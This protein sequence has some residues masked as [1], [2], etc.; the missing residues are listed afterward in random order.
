[1]ADNNRIKVSGYAKKI[2]FNDNIEYRNFS[3]DLVGFQ[4]TSEGGTTLFT[5]G[6]FS[7]TVN[8]DPKPNVLFTQGTKSKFYTLNDIS[9]SGNTE[10]EIQKNVRAKLNIDITNPLSYIWYGSTKELLRASLIEIEDNW[11]AAIYV[12]NKVGS[13]T[14]NNITNYVYD[15]SKDESTFIVNSNFFINPYNITYTLDSQYEPTESNKNKLRNFTLKY[16]SYVIEHNGIVKNIK[17]ITPTTYKTNSDLSL[18]V[19]GNPFPELTGIYIPQLSFLSNGVDASIPYFIKP[20]EIEI[21][22]FFSGLNELQTNLLNREI[23]P[24]YRSEIIGTKFT[25]AGVILNSKELY[26]FPILEDGYNLNFFDSFYISYLDKLNEFTE[27]LDKTK[28]DLILRKYTTEVI[29]SFDTIPRG[30]GDDLTLN[31]EKVTNLLRIYGVEFDFIKKFINGIKFANV[32]TYNKKNN[33]PDALVKDLSYMLG[34]DP[35]NFISDSSLN[36]LYL[37]SNGGG[38]FS[39]TSTNLTQDQIDFELYRRLILNIAW[40]WKS[41]GSRKAIE[42]LFR[43]IGAPES[44]VNFNEYIVIVDKPLD[45]EEIKKLLYI[46]TG[47]V[48]LTNIPYD[49]NGFPLPPIDGNLVVSNFIDPE[50]GEIVENGTTDMYFQKAGGWYRDTYGDS[51]PTVLNGNNPHIGPYDGG[52]EYLQYFS[53]CYIPNFDNEPTVVLTANTIQE[54][55]FINYNYGIFNGIPKGTTEFY[56]S[57]LTFN[58]NTNKYQP[59]GSCVDINYSIIETPLQN[60]GKTTLQQAYGEAESQYNEFLEKIKKDKYL[61]YSPEWQVI[62]NNYE[63]SLKN[64]LTEIETENCDTNNTLEICLNDIEEETVKFNC[65]KTNSVV[66][67]PFFYFTNNDGVKVSVD[68]FDVC[69]SKLGGKH[70]SYINE[71]GRDAEFCYTGDKDTGPC[72]GIPQDP[73]DNGIIPFLMVNNTL[74]NNVIQVNSSIDNDYSCYQFIYD[75]ENS[76]FNLN[77][78]LENFQSIYGITPQQYINTYL[79]TGENTTPL[80]YDSGPSFESLFSKVSCEQTSVVSSPECCAYHGYDYTILT[81]E[82]KNSY[83]ACLQNNNNVSSLVFQ[84]NLTNS[85]FIETYTIPIIDTS[86]N[87]SYYELQ[88]PV[89]NVSLY[90]TTN[91]FKDCFEESVIVKGFSNSDDTAVVVPGPNSDFLNSELN[92]PEN[93]E[94]SSIDVYGR[95]SFKPLSEYNSNLIVDWNSTGILALLYQQIAE[96]YPQYSF[97]TFVLNDNGQVVPYV[98]SNQSTPNNYFIALVDPELVICQNFNNIS[99]MFGSE[100]WQGFKLPEFPVDETTGE[101]IEDCSCSIDFSFDYMLKYEASNLIECA[102]NVSCF[103]AIFYENSVNNINCRN[104]ISFTNNSEDSQELI[105]RFNPSPL[106]SNDNTWSGIDVNEPNV[107]CCSA[108]GGNVVSVSQ[109]ATSNQIW[110]NQINDIYTNL[111]SDNPSTEILDNLSNLNIVYTDMLFYIQEYKRIKSEVESNIGSCFS[112]TLN[113][114]NCNINYGNY[115]NTQS[116]CNLE[117]PVEC[118]LWT[119]ILTDLESLKNGISNLISEYNVQCISPNPGP[120]DST[121]KKSEEFF[122]GVEVVKKQNALTTQEETQLKVLTES[123]EK[124]ILEINSLQSEIDLKNSDNAVIEKSLTNVNNPLDCNVYENKLTELRN[125]DYKSYCNTIV[126]GNPSSNDGTKQNEYNSCTKSKTLE[127]QN[128]EVTYSQLLVSCREKNILESQLTTAKFEN[129]ITLINELEKEIFELNQTINRLTNDINNSISFDESKQKSLLEQNDIQ[130]TINRTS[131]L[132]NVTPESITD[133]SGNILLTSTQKIN[134]N[135]IYSKNIT[136]INSLNTKIDESRALLTENLEKQNTI[137]RN[138]KNE[139]NNLGNT[140]LGW[141]VGLL[142]IYYTLKGYLDPETTGVIM[143]AVGTTGI[144]G[145]GGGEPIVKGCVISGGT[146]YGPVLDSS[147]PTG[148]YFYTLIGPSTQAQDPNATQICDNFNPLNSGQWFF[149]GQQNGSPIYQNDCCS[150]TRSSSNPNT[151][152]SSGGNENSGIPNQEAPVDI[153]LPPS[154]GVGSN[155]NPLPEAEP[156]KDEPGTSTS[157][158]SGS[159]NTNEQGCVWDEIIAQPDGS[160]I[161]LFNGQTVPSECCDR[162]ILLTNFDVDFVNGE[163]VMTN[164]SVEGTVNQTLVNCCSN[165]NIEKL[166]ELLGETDIIYQEV[167]TITQNCYDSWGNSLQETYQEYEEINNSYYANYLDD[168]KVNFKLFVNNST[169]D[170]N[171]EIDSNLTYLPYTESVNPI[172]T[173]N[174]TTGYT[175]IILEGTE[176]EIATIED[177]IFNQLSTQNITYNADMFEPNWQTFNFTIPECVC[178]DL[179]RLYPNKEF[180]FSIEIENYECSLCLLVDNIQV[181]VSDCKTQRLLSINDCM[182]PQL[183]CV[184]DNKKSWVYYDDGVVTENVYPNGECNTGS[185]NNYEVVRL[186][187]EQERLWLDLEYR[188]TD[189]NVNHSDLILN[190]KNSSFSIDPAKAIECDVFNYWKNIDCDNCPTKCDEDSK[191]YEDSDDFLFQDCDTYIFEGQSTEHSVVFSGEV[192][193]TGYTLSFDDVVTTGLI[194]SCSTYTDS[195]EQTVL[196]LKNK[197][198]ALTSDYNASLGA[199][200]YQLLEKGGSLDNFYIQ[201]NNCG[202]DT[203]VI[204][205]NSSLDN[206]FGV[207]TENYDGTISLFENY[208]YTGST[209]YSGGV[210]S[211][212]LSGTGVTAQTFNQKSEIDEDCCKSLNN[213][214]NSKGVGGLGLG[215]NYVWSEENCGCYW[216]P[217]TEC[218]GCK[219]DC[220]YCGTEKTCVDGFATGDTYGVCINPLDYLDIQPSEI[221]IKAVFDQL[222]QTNLIDVKS[223]QTISDYPLLRLFY[224]LYLNANNC[225]EDLSGKFTYNTMFGFMDKIGDY[226]LDLI[227]QVVPATTIWEGCDNSGKIYRNTIFDNNKF[228]YKRYSTNFIEVTTGCTLSAQTDFSIGSETTYTSVEQKPIYPSSP[229]ITNK[230]LD[231]RQKEVEIALLKKEIEKQN[232]ILCSLNLQDLSTPNLQTLIDNQQN[233]IDI[234]NSESETLNQQLIVLNNDLETLENEYLEQQENYTMNFMSCSGITQNLINA[235]N[236]LSGFTQGTTAYE[237]QRNFIAGLRDKYNKCIRKSNKL[238]SNYNT[239][240]ITQ[241]YDSNEYEGNVLIWGDSDFDTPEFTKTLPPTQISGF[242]YNQELIHNCEN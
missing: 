213:L 150:A 50:T 20:N 107:E 173:W 234:L 61:I 68:E 143:A 82:N 72:I 89:G 238:I 115:I 11:P 39:G 210:L 121:I 105:N 75:T 56:T 203:I 62:K 31:G 178:D 200:Y 67:T 49:K 154:G 71:Y 189:Y 22:K 131:E 108:I 52:S 32:V 113:S 171:T 192:V 225:G 53:R 48:D 25:D 119:N 100:N 2:F 172:W 120:I 226:W 137:V 194:F 44:L 76:S 83:V 190:V 158:G 46:Y 90:Y 156:D 241:I 237:T 65:E 114:S 16:G 166:T 24:K 135:V 86:V 128:E 165:T 148:E 191:A 59:I 111:K 201:N 149:Q 129:N 64:C 106:L 221:N 145:G 180:F 38:E 79:L 3:P 211:E 94:V 136:Q 188:Y 140:L 36:K 236:N 12:D 7:I 58:P 231:I 57:Q 202:T 85:S 141:G 88:N 239:I 177:G 69:C 139:K 219:G 132:L 110:V 146:T 21:E 37:P 98:P 10:L 125:F 164:P 124:L 102:D 162:N 112:L 159:N 15:I 175:G 208:L 28:T 26:D 228:N 29:S 40:L 152:S 227:E 196:S 1:M 73:L 4:L 182:I 55:F 77:I 167:Q 168:L 9:S 157:S 142:G 92:F 204:N 43:F 78:T 218:N 70:I 5:N 222:V 163:C 93:W 130:N 109:W 199:T 195:L 186:G 60:D 223:R 185:T 206:L 198:Y 240:F 14:G 160:G 30:E 54:N 96:L 155:T 170:S 133:E 184:I 63:V 217:I 179:R 101:V 34:L 161:I 126:Y 91:V 174:P 127:N 42:F 215:K 80:G 84:S 74:P 104:F 187:Q 229:Q 151:G 19:D 147:S 212:V 232:K 224:E 99:V 233:Q 18:I 117:V 27:N 197:Y 97:G 41:K 95:I 66:C 176:E 214:L 205:D 138:T 118:G 242:Y 6:N 183:S 45:I 134:L 123:N 122:E 51:S 144:K 207:I 23:Y 153:L 116:I 169:I 13:V 181:N 193:S 17:N 209:P 230:K 235:Q 8:L 81:D 33:I 35:I 216:Q 47:E 220:E 103:P 87:D